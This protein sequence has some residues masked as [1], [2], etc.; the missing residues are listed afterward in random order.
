MSNFDD[1]DLDPVEE[2]PETVEETPEEVVAPAPDPAA[3]VKLEL[4]PEYEADG[5][6]TV[7]VAA[8]GPLVFEKGKPVTVSAED[9]LLLVQ[10]PAVKEVN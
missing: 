4:D 2:S 1:F 5:P 6:V 8:A 7:S 10:S 3:D 9:A